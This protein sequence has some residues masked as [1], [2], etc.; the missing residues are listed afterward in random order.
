MNYLTFTDGLV[1][2]FLLG[3]MVM[4][5]IFLYLNATE[6]EDMTDEEK[7]YWDKD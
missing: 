5:S 7:Q 6:E 1:Y 2:G 3:A 4:V